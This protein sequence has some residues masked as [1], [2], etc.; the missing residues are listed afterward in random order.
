MILEDALE[1][2]VVASPVFLLGS[3]TYL[4]QVLW[5]YIVPNVKMYT[6]QDR[7]IKAV[8]FFDL[9]NFVQ[10]GRIMTRSLK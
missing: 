2:T 7:S 10:I 8:S 9:A 4:D 6:I 3:R 5:K 1:S